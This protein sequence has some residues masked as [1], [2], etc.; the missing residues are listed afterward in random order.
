MRHSP[1]KATIAQIW[2]GR[3]KA[4][5]ADEYADYLYEAGIKPLEEPWAS[6]CCVRTALTKASS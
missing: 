3:V 2:R 6:R 4:A 1:S 5:R